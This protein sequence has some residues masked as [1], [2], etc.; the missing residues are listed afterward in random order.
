MAPNLAVGFASGKIC[1]YCVPEDA[2]LLGT[3]AS[4]PLREKSYPFTESTSLDSFLVDTINAHRA[5]VSSLYFDETLLVSGDA[6]GNL[7]FLFF[8]FTHTLSLPI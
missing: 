4:L 1:L 5:P 3:F 6:L 8:V 2:D 7:R